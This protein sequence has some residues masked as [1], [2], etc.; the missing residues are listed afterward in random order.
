MKLKASQLFPTPVLVTVSLGLVV[1]LAGCERTG[2]IA[3]LAYRLEPPAG[4][5]SVYEPHIAIDPVSPDR[6]AVGAQHGIRGGRGG[7][8]LQVWIS[9]DA[10]RT[11]SSSRVPRPD[12]D[13]GFSAD[14]LVFFNTDGSVLFAGLSG[15]QTYADFLDSRDVSRRS[16]PTIEQ[17]LAGMRAN[18][19]AIPGLLRGDTITVSRSEDGGRTFTST[20]IAG[21]PGGDKPAV[22]VDRSATSPFAG[23]VYVLWGD[24]SPSLRVVRS[25]DGGRTFTPPAVLDCW[26][27]SQG[28]QLA[29]RPDGTVHVVW[30]VLS[31]PGLTTPLPSRRAAPPE[32][33]ASIYHA[34]SSD[35]GATFSQP[36]P[37]ATHAGPGMV[38]IPSLAVDRRGRLLWVWGQA[39]TL[40]DLKTRPILQPRH[41]LFG[42][43][44]DD[45]VT[46]SRPFLLLPELPVTTHMGLPAVVSDGDTWWV[47]TYLA[48]DEE[49]RVVLLRSEKGGDGGTNFRVDRTLATRS[50]PVDEMSLLGSYLLR[51]CSD[52]AQVGD[53]VGIAAAGSR[54]VAA[55]ILPET[56]DP[57]S[58]ARAYV[59][60]HDMSP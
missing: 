22:A 24:M 57:T 51:S 5:V 36:R 38:G 10:G 46:W 33:A 8:A 21:S 13:A 39:E 6:I 40:P 32:A 7:R 29:V 44:S 9:H 19:S 53:Y 17:H 25:A 4:G 12:G 50:I 14:P 26:G 30:Y 45:G 20:L 54:V 2:T 35:G 43:R 18:A 49:T 58:T 27:P 41:R 1:C 23:S 52:A 3:K 34:F 60:V 28:S 59:A 48:D 15:P 55:F 31:L 56:D 42:I 47:V 11:W 16:A 37:V